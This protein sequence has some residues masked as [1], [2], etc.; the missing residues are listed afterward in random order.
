[1][2][3]TAISGGLRH[4]VRQ[5]DPRDGKAA[6]GAIPSDPK[7]PVLSERK[8]N[9][10]RLLAP[11]AE[12]IAF[13]NNFGELMIR[14][15]IYS[16]SAGGHNDEATKLESFKRA[17]ISLLHMHQS[18]QENAVDTLLGVLKQR[19]ET[20][21][22]KASVLGSRGEKE[23]QT[24]RHMVEVLKLLAERENLGLD[25]ASH[26]KIK[27]ALPALESQVKVEYELRND[28]IKGL[29]TV[30]VKPEAG[31]LLHRGT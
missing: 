19:V 21:T 8:A 25:K 12:Q 2:N 24:T 30:I 18:H 13:N 26:A 14:G 9:P 17:V 31:A 16:A 1:M 27:D 20:Y 11:T 4:D 23:F 22:R 3:S 15:V 28:K 6:S 5:L 7:A 29:H 10:E